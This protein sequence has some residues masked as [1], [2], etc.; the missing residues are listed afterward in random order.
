MIANITS[1]QFK[2]LKHCGALNDVKVSF[3]FR[4]GIVCIHIHDYEF[5]TF[6]RALRYL[7][8]D[9]RMI[10]HDSHDDSRFEVAV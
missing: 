6:E 2:Y 10:V 3:C 1:Q 8:E 7:Q 9:S 5:E 4:D